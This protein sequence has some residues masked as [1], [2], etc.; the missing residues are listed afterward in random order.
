MSE[1][2]D[3]YEQAIRLYDA[4]DIE[5]FADAHAEDAVLETPVGTTRGRAA[6]RDYWLRQKAAFPDLVLTLDE[7]VE[8]GD[9]VAAEW[10]WVGTNTGRLTQ[11]DGS[12]LPPTGNRVRIKGMELLHFRD[13]RITSYHMFWDRMSI[14][15]QLGLLPE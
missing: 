14:A 2:R 15:R 7:V 10:T 11:P 5:R 6:I 1:I 8:Q 12:Q 3:L 13:G 4:G 9:A